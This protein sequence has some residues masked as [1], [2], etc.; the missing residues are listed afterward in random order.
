MRTML[1]IT[2]LAGTLVAAACSETRSNQRSAAEMQASLFAAA[3]DRQWALPDRLREISGLAVSP[4]G[5]V[6]VHDDET[7]AIHQF[8]VERGEF[9]KMFMLGDRPMRGDFEGLAITPAGDFWL[10]TSTGDFYRFREGRDGEHV[11]YERFNAGTEHVCEL[12]GL[13][14]LASEN[15]LILACKRN[16]DRAMRDTPL[17]LSWP[18]GDAVRP[19]EWRRAQTNFA[20]ASDVRRFQPSSVEIDART[21]RI[22]LLSANDA[23]LAELDAGGTLL[24]AR[25]LGR[26]HPQP[27]GLAIL[28]DGSLLIADEGGDGQARLS[29]YSRNP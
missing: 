18:P 10:M 17:L 5:H 23:A 8:D 1:L 19:T 25:A 11:G 12:E 9:V 24:A 29:H 6:F 4:E 3:P 27:E 7:A 16:H 22:I 2:L 28:P 14:Y 13:T 15:S 26:A 20:E 21:G